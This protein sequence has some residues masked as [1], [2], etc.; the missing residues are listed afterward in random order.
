MRMRALPLGLIIRGE[1][2]TT[3]KH[4]Q[5]INPALVWELSYRFDRTSKWSRKHLHV[6]AADVEFTHTT[7]SFGQN[8][9]ATHMYI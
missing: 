7:N 8:F 1:C 3:Y 4:L 5:Y 6:G 2:N 9:S